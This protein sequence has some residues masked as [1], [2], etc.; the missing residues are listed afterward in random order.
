M[1]V[2]VFFGERFFGQRPR[3]YTALRAVT[4]GAHGTKGVL[5]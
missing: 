4:G 3:W 1:L 2:I 5:R